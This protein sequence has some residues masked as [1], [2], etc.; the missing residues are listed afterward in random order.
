MHIRALVLAASLALLATPAASAQDQHEHGHEHDSSAAAVTQLQLDGGKRWPTDASLRQGMADIHAAFEADHPTIHAGKQ[1]DAQYEALAGHIESQVNSIVANCKLPPAA[2]ANLHF[3]VADL[4]Q[5]I[6]LMRGQDPARTRH[7]G[8][9]L[10]HGALR[11]YGQYFDD[12]DW[13]P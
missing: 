8:A 9:A 4:L 2:D 11:A 12:P 10:V 7:D 6:G 1:T 5:G 3:V 13:K